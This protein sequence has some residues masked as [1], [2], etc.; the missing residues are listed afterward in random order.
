[1]G[2]EKGPSGSCWGRNKVPLGHHPHTN[3]AQVNC[4]ERGRN[5]GVRCGNPKSAVHAGTDV[6]ARKREPPTAPLSGRTYLFR[7]R[8]HRRKRNAAETSGFE[9]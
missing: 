2:Q 9:W 4:A 1:M 3:Q 5:D 6:W 8:S 7:P